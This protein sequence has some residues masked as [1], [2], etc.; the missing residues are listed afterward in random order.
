[1]YTFQCSSN[2]AVCHNLLGVEGNPVLQQT[3]S[4]SLVSD[5]VWEYWGG[6]A[7]AGTNPG[8]YQTPC[9][10]AFAGLEFH[11]LSSSGFWFPQG[12][13][14]QPRLASCSVSLLRVGCTGVST[15]T[16]CTLYCSTLGC[17]QR[18]AP[19]FCLCYGEQLSRPQPSH[20]SLIFS[21]LYLLLFFPSQSVSSLLSQPRCVYEFKSWSHTWE[22][23][24]N[25][26]LSMVHFTWQDD[27]QFH[28]FFWKCCNF[29]LFITR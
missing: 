12:L 3:A 23:R 13:S 7:G 29:I 16:S 19:A 20:Y 17:F 18:A 24:C 1:M 5:S 8:V 2:A 21:L 4:P 22:K 15:K 28:Q 25:V 14:V 26:C 10:E 11:S 9:L 6:G 27:L